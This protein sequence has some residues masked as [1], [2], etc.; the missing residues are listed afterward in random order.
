[1][2]AHSDSTGDDPAAVL[3]SP[4]RSW[5]SAWSGG[6]VL[7]GLL[8]RP[9]VLLVCSP[10]CCLDFLCA[11][12]LVLLPTRSAKSACLSLLATPP[13]IS[14]LLTWRSSKWI[15]LQNWTYSGLF[16]FP[17][18]QKTFA[19]HTSLLVS[20]C[21]RRVLHAFVVAFWRRP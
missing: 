7:E 21:R 19:S 16:T 15:R 9:R 5:E 14:P 20:D 1:M 17:A 12:L 8:V 13:S 18:C 6:S 4:G 11:T 10:V 2:F 3:S